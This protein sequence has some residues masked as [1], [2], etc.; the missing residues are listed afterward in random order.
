MTTQEDAQM[1]QARKEISALFRMYDN[2]CAL[3]RR[4]HHRHR[5]RFLQ[6]QLR[7]SQ[8]LRRTVP[9]QEAGHRVNRLGIP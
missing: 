4:R 8:L 2:D 5:H 9:A 3:R 7:V 6:T 1:E